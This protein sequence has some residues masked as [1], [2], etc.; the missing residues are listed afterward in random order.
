MSG[1]LG[2][3]NQVIRHFWFQH[4]E[5]MAAPPASEEFIGVLKEETQASDFKIVKFE[6]T[7]QGRMM[8]LTS[9]KLSAFRQL[10]EPLNVSEDKEL[11]VEEPKP[12]NPYQINKVI[13]LED[14][15]F[16]LYLENQLED[17][18]EVTPVI[19]SNVKQLAW[20]VI[21]KEAG[22]KTGDDISG[23]PNKVYNKDNSITLKEDLSEL[24]I[25]TPVFTGTLKIEWGESLAPTIKPRNVGYSGV[26][27]Y[28][29]NGLF[30][31]N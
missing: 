27:L 26:G 5:G 1:T 10:F 22:F 24:T 15:S 4:A 11:W 14:G 31:E 3:Y 21:N 30:P 16:G 28:L 8:N 9:N 18:Q 17:G 25:N 19:L 12:M 7:E 13:L 29:V 6:E 23:F 20:E 2:Q